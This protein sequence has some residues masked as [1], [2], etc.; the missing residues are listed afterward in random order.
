MRSGKASLAT[1]PSSLTSVVGSTSSVG[2]ALKPS[3]VAVASSKETWSL[4]FPSSGLNPAFASVLKPF[5][6]PGNPPSAT[7]AARFLGWI[8]FESCPGEKAKGLFSTLNCASSPGSALRISCWS[9]FRRA[10]TSRCICSW[11]V[12]TFVDGDVEAHDP[13]RDLFVGTASVLVSSNGD[14]EAWMDSVV[15]GSC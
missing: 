2:E 10:S 6:R 1:W 14:G 13:A 12:P 4:S 11:S 9:P 15:P 8:S 5:S 7:N 3:F